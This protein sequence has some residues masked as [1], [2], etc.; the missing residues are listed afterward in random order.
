MKLSSEPAEVAALEQHQKERGSQV[1]A[2]G[3]A[4]QSETP[5]AFHLA[6]KTI[7]LLP[8]W[9]VKTTKDEDE[10]NMSWSHVT[11]GGFKVPCL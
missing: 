1:D 8:F 2:I 7:T 4:H 6:G 10:A 3:H 11:Q 9:F 5:T